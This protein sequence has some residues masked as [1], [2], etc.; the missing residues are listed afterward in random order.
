MVQVSTEE[1]PVQLPVTIRG[2][3]YDEKETS[4]NSYNNYNKQ[5]S[6]PVILFQSARALLSE[7]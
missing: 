5:F 1:H 7:D 3:L 6:T 2:C 4:D